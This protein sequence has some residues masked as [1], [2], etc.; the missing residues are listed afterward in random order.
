MI[1]LFY[2]KGYIG[3]GWKE[4][5][6]TEECDKIAKHQKESRVITDFLDW[7]LDEKE[8]LFAAYHEDKLYAEHGDVEELLAEYFKIDLVKAEQERMAIL[9]SLRKQKEEI[10]QR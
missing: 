8:Y 1:A 5:M 7:V 9:E 6:E 3:G 4:D 10:C 2:D